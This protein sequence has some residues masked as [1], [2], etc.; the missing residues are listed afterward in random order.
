MN[1]CVVSC[2][3]FGSTKSL[4]CARKNISRNLLNSKTTNLKRLCG[5]EEVSKA[6]AIVALN[7]AENAAIA[8]SMAQMP[9]WDEAALAANEIKMAMEIYN[10]VYDFKLGKTVVKSL[11]M[12]LLGNRLGT[13]AF[14]AASKLITWIPGLGN[15]LNAGVAGTTTAALGAAIIDSA[16]EMDRARRN[17]KW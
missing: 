7:V 5:P 12:G 4:L 8:A 15:G 6:K 13:T 2:T 9:G 10:G 1:V 16:E 3:N 11:V 17:G 14:K